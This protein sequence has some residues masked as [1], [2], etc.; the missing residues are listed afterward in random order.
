ME[1]CFPLLFVT[2]SIYFFTGANMKG[3]SLEGS[4]MSGINLRLGTLKRANMQNC[5]LRDAILAGADLEVI[6]RKL[7]VIGE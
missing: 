7:I 5:T 4:Q 2:I 1:I 3:V 6:L